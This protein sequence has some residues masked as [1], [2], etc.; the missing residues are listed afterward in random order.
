M[1]CHFASEKGL[2]D[3]PIYEN[4]QKGNR[5]YTKKIGNLNHGQ[6]LVLA[7]T[8]QTPG[9]SRDEMGPGIFNGNPEGPQEKGIK[10][11]VVEPAGKTGKQGRIQ[12]QE[13][14]K[15]NERQEAYGQGEVPILSQDHD[16]PV[17][18]GE[19]MKKP[20]N[21]TQL[22]CIAGGF[23]QNGYEQGNEGNPREK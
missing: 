20:R 19:I 7:V 4:D 18:K 1:F 16:D 9:E 22:E 13:E 11:A 12:G 15:Q 23:V 10:E 8:Q 2:E 21:E 17:Y 14:R 5:I 6:V 3:Q